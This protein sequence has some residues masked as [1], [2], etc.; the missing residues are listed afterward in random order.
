MNGITGLGS[1]IDY[2]VMQSSYDADRVIEIFEDAI[3]KG[4]H[5]ETVEQDVYR[6]ARVNPA[7]F[8]EFD[9]KRIALKVNEIYEMYQTRR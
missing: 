7:D 1:G 5:P 6:Q 2:M 4:Y 9:K 8:T 3:S